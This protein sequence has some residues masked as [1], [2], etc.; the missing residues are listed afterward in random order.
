MFARVDIAHEGLEAIRGELHGTPQ[1]HAQRAGR[2]L[3]RIDVDLDAEAPAHVPTDDAHVL[4]GQIQ[5]PGE[6]VLHHVGRLEGVVH[7]EPAL[8]RIEVGE[9]GPGL[10]GHPGMAAHGERLA[11]HDVRLAEG[12]VRIAG[13]QREREG[14]V[15]PQLWM[16]HGRGGIERRRRVGDGGPH[17]PGHSHAGGAVLGEG[18]ALRHHRGHRFPL[19]G[20]L[21]HGE[22]ALHRRFHPLEMGKGTDPAR[23]HGGHGLARDHRGHARQRRRLV[24]VDGHHARVSMGAPHEGDVE[25]ARKHHVVGE[26]TAAREETGGL[27]AH[28]ALA[29]VAPARLDAA[30]AR[31]R[32]SA[33]LRTAATMA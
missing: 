14:E 16:D 29:D 26:D 13:G 1:H 8:G 19:P 4:L 20:R 5:M 32:A 9:D 30:H 25:H 27:R 24:S 12:R 23:A 21:A 17:L 22:R 15:V 7:G 31:A 11:Q 10:E 2:H 6:D 3:V 28:H 33:A 18:A